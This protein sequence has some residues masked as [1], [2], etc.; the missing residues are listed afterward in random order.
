MFK[1]IKRRDRKE[2]KKRKVE[3]VIHIGA[4]KCGSSAIQQF[5]VNHRETLLEK[6]YY[7]PVH[8][9]DVNGVSGGHTEFAGP[10]LQGDIEQAKDC[11]LGWLNEAREYQACLLISSEMLYGQHLAIAKL[12]EGITIEVVAFLRHPV[13]YLLGNH[14]QG[15]KRHM[16]TRRLGQLLIEQIGKPA[17]HLVGLPLLKWADSFGDNQCHF[18]AYRTPS[19]GGSPI[20]RRFLE[21]LGI[22]ATEADML[23]GKVAITNRSYVTSAL[24]LKRLLNTVL[25]ELPDG[26]AH[27]VDWVLQGYSDKAQNERG[28]TQADIPERVRQQL[29][30]ELMPQMAPVVT[31]FADLAEAAEM[32]PLTRQTQRPAW[33]DLSAPLE[34]LEQREPELMNQIR[35][36]AILLRDNGRCDYTFFKLLDVLGID[37]DETLVHQEPLNS[38]ARRVLASEKSRDA[39]VLREMAVMLERLGYLEDAMLAIEQALVRRPKGRGILKIQQRIAEKLKV[40]KAMM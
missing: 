21:V 26:L 34:M 39:D 17:P 11:F 14:N 9:L 35:Q 4:P 36:T 28:L 37:F 12:C 2:I 5:C 6:G 16:Q 1:F 8:R 13:D 30:D 10:L 20:E 29:L 31:R 7:Y 33:L 23:V 3:V 32:A 22:S 18:L 27:R 38:A 40:R 24:E 25:P 15:I 19:Q